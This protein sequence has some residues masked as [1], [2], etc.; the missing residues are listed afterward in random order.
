[1]HDLNFEWPKIVYIKIVRE[2]LNVIR[3]FLRLGRRE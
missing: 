2:D 3:Y 1:M